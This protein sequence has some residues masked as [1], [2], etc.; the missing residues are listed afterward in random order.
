MPTLP[1]T[2]APLIPGL[3]KIVHIAFFAVFTFLWN[4]RFSRQIWGVL[5][6]AIVFGIAVEYLQD[7]MGLGRSF[8]TYD[9]V[10]DVAGALLGLVFKQ[11]FEK[12]IKRRL[13]N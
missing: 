3:D 6:I 1:S 4:F 11:V 12:F 10:A 13:E 5:L 9:I 7:G 2:S 8:D